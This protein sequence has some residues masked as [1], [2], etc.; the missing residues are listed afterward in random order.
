MQ[1]PWFN[2]EK[3]IVESKVDSKETIKKF[4]SGKSEWS[5]KL[6]N[7]SSSKYLLN[8]SV[9]QVN[10]GWFNKDS[11]NGTTEVLGSVSQYQAPIDVLIDIIVSTTVSI[12]LHQFN[13]CLREKNK[14]T[15]P[16]ES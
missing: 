12:R 13:D 1:K 6:P 15:A 10:I 16:P 3:K 9:A 14:L 5:T 8:K 4:K 11:V 7:I 2:L